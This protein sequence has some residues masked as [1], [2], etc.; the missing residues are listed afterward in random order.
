MMMMM[1]ITSNR[2]PKKTKAVETIK[3]SEETE[4]GKE[5]LGRIKITSKE[6][7]LTEM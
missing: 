1:W 2:M 4:A 5:I 6:E 3:Q 7:S